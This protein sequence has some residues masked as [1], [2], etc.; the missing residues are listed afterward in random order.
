[1]SATA[2]CRKISA[3]TSIISFSLWIGGN[4]KYSTIDEHGSKIARDIAFDCHLSPVGQQIAIKTLFLGS[5]DLRS[6]IA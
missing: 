1:M 6:S 3:F 4:R 2:L 5:F